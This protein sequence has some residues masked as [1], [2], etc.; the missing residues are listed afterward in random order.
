MTAA[1]ALVML[2]MYDLWLL[3]ACMSVNLWGS[4]RVTGSSI[5]CFFLVFRLMVS[6]KCGVSKFFLLFGFGLFSFQCIFL[7][8][9][10]DSFGMFLY[11]SRDLDLFL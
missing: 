3:A 4:W 8:K 5:V 10:F 7:M 11:R 1:L 6:A 9:I 2:L